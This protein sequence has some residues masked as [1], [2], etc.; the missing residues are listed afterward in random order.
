MDEMKRHNHWLFGTLVLNA[1]DLFY[2][3]T[4]GKLISEK[5][6]NIIYKFTDNLEFGDLGCKG[7]IKN[8]IQ[9]IDRTYEFQR[10]F[11]NHN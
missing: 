3:N 6:P 10:T 4:H 11:Y 8:E 5:K 2:S 9:Y 7:Q 1:L